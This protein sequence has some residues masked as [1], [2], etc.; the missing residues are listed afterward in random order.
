V[1]CYA[2]SE[3]PSNVIKAAEGQENA[4]GYRGFFFSDR[5]YQEV[6]VTP[7]SRYRASISVLSK[8]R[9]NQRMGSADKAMTDFLLVWLF[10][11]EPVKTQYHK[12]DWTKDKGN[13]WQ[14]LVIT[15]TVPK[16]V[17]GV[18]FQ[19]RPRQYIDNEEVFFKAP[20]LENI[21]E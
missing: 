9:N 19:V 7:G 11:G 2:D 13:G 18:R 8:D 3:L 20:I 6:P 16:G 5:F 10:D 1:G 4:F 14:N 15:A 12:S 17:N 21:N